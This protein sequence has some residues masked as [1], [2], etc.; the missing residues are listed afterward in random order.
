[1]GVVGHLRQVCL[2]W[3]NNLVYKIWRDW[4]HRRAELLSGLSFYGCVSC[5]VHPP[6]SRVGS[7]AKKRTH[8]V[9]YGSVVILD[10]ALTKMY[11][12]ETCK[13]YCI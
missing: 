10:H 6:F 4:V 13:L 7:E 9:A 2:E 3:D 5:Q 11:G 8:C 1:M 12:K